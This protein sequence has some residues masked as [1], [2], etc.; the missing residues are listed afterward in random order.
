MARQKSRVMRGS[1]MSDVNS[2]G[3]SRAAKQRTV[4]LFSIGVR[5]RGVGSTLCIYLWIYSILCLSNQKL[6]RTPSLCPAML[7]CCAMLCLPF[8]LSFL[9]PPFIPPLRPSCHTSLHHFNLLRP[10]LPPSTPTHTSN[11]PILAPLPAPLSAP[12]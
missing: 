11:P 9:L 4:F 12:H 7:P 2:R 10:H 5:Q 8:C 6:F 1:L 3:Y